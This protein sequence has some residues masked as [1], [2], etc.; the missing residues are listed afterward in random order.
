[1]RTFCA[2]VA[3]LLALC[4]GCAGPGAPEAAVNRAM[5]QEAATPEI[6]PVS[7][8]GGLA[9][10]TPRPSQ[11]EPPLVEVPEESEE[12]LPW[13]YPISREILDDEQDVLR[14]VNANNLLDKDYPGEDMLVEVTVRKANSNEMLA[15]AVASEALQAMFDAADEDGLKLYLYSAYRNYRSQEVIH[16]NRVEA[17]GYDDGIVQVAGG[18][19]HQTGLAFDVISYAWIGSRFNEDFADTPEGQWMA[20]NCTRFGFIIRYPEGKQDIT[21][22]E[23]EPWH[24][25]Y[26]GVEVATYMTEKGLTLEEFTVE[27]RNAVFDYEMQSQQSMSIDSF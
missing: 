12:A 14:L 25:R 7:E 13:T 5:A 1:M 20:E 15:R 3:F 21:G 27:W 2:T 18:S 24:L 26:V 10:S 9:F 11:T 16:Y 19:E 4:L 17:M 23:Y 22:I 6:A 8:S